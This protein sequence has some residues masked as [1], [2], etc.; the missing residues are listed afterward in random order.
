M[1]AVQKN[2]MGIMVW[3]VQSVPDTEPTSRYIRYVFRK[4]PY[5]TKGMYM[6]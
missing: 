4:N 5:S 1:I 6:L 2:D 3:E